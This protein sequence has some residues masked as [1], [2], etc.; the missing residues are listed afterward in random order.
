M[1]PKTLRQVPAGDVPGTYAAPLPPDQ[2]SLNEVYLTFQ[3]ECR[4]VGTPTIFIRTSHCPLRCAWCDSK[5]TFTEGKPWKLADV[6]AEVKRLGPSHVCLTGGEPLAQPQSVELVRRL[7]EQGFT[8]EVETSGS[9]P[10]D[11]LAALPK[12]LRRLVTINLDVKCPGSAMANFNRWENLPLLQAHDQLKFILV[13][14]ADYEYA[15]DVLKRH[16]SAAQAWLH[17]AWK[18]LDPKELAEW[19]K[20]DALSAQFGVQVHKY[21]WGD[22][23]GV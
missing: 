16:R 21:V 13:D 14:R 11:A 15:K 23:R 7:A 6:M 10:I 18:Q 17:P 12:A 4:F 9:E 22:A 20:A 1:T 5:Y 19:M 3:G 2:I 8:V